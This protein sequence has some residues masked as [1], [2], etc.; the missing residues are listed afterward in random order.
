MSG[1]KDEQ[2]E[3][4]R[5]LVSLYS[6]QGSRTAEDGF[7]ARMTLAANLYATLMTSIEHDLGRKE[8]TTTWSGLS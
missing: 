2:E 4:L 1:E 5:R 6:I 3:Q 8:R 7:A